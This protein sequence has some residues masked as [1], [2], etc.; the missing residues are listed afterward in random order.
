V[1]EYAQRTA[2]AL[3]AMDDRA[4]AE[5]K[6]WLWQHSIHLVPEVIP[7]PLGL[8]LGL[9]EGGAAIALE[10]DGTWRD[11]VD[12]GL[13]FDRT[14][15]AALARA[16]LAPQA[17]AETRSLIRQARAAF[18]RTASALGE[19]LVPTSPKADLWAPTEDLG[20]DVRHQRVEDEHRWWTPEIRLPH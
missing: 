11:R 17:A 12:R 1:Q 16:A 9:G 20:F 3:D 19:R 18:D 5:S 4:E 7:G 13:R 8:V 6:Q 14:D 15:A 10:T 2:H